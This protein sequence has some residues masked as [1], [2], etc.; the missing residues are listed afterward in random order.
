MGQIEKY[1]AIGGNRRWESNTQPL[2]CWGTYWSE[3]LGLNKGTKKIDLV[4][5]FKSNAKVNF[6]RCEATT[7]NGLRSSNRY[8]FLKIL[9]KPV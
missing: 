6:I 9:V 8:S 1:V 5:I 2:E 7:F 3:P 4:S